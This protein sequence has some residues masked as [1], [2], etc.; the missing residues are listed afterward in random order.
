MEN[1]SAI[2]AITVDSLAIVT[3]VYNNPY[4]IIKYY[5]FG[6]YKM[7]EK[8]KIYKIKNIILYTMIIAARFVSFNLYVLCYKLSRGKR[9]T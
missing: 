8:I 7:T 9:I 4:N 1:D 6:Y 2:C 5:V 3:S